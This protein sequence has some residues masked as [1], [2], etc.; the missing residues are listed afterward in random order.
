MEVLISY[1]PAIPL[2]SVGAHWEFLHMFRD[3]NKDIYT[4]LCI[5]IKIGNI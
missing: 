2:S 1:N 3:M 5:M 4:V